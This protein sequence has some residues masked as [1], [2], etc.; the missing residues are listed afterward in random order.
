MNHDDAAIAQSS[1]RPACCCCCLHVKVFPLFSTTFTDRE[2]S[3]QFSSTIILMPLTQ[4]KNSLGGKNYNVRF[5][6][7]S[8][9]VLFTEM[10]KKRYN[11]GRSC[12]NS[13]VAIVV[14][15]TTSQRFLALQV[16]HI[17][18]D[19]FYQ[20]KCSSE[21]ATTIADLVI[22]SVVAN[23]VLYCD[24]IRRLLQTLGLSSWRVIHNA[25][26]CSK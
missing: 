12:S 5:R 18:D 8:R 19:M 17:V 21:M 6:S 9:R 16:K 20:I 22:S 2:F 15:I 26:V 25:T 11:G 10:T 4:R 23:L 3:S 14:V 1:N 24:L 7:I 13:I